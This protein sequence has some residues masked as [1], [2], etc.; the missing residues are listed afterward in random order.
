MLRVAIVN[1]LSYLLRYLVSQHPEVE[2]RILQELAQ[3]S[4]MPSADGSLRDIQFEDLGRLTYLNCCIKV[5]AA[6]FP[7]CLVKVFATIMLL[8]LAMILAKQSDAID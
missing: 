4:L 8:L 2:Q 3:H 5:I 6:A 1:Q 7:S